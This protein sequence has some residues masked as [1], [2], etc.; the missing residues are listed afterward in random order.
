MNKDE[1]KDS[2]KIVEFRI[3]LVKIETMNREKK[4]D[5]FIFLFLRMVFAITPDFYLQLPFEYKNYFTGVSQELL[6]QEKLSSKE[7]N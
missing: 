7:S 2:T 3:D 1:K 5:F 6:N 4:L